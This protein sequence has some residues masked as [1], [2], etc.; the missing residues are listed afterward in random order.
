VVLIDA[1]EPISE[2]DQRVL[3]MVVDAGRA[4]VIALNKWDL[5]DDDRRHYLARELERDLRRIPWA[6]RV[7][8]SAKTG[9][10]VD[11]LAPALHTALASWEQRV[12]TGPLNQWLTAVVNATPHPVRSGRSPK[13]LFATQ[14][15]TRPPRFVLFTSGPLDASYVRFIERRLREEYGFAGSPVVVSVRSRQRK[16]ARRRSA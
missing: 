10:A 1:S 9:R 5:V 7:N 8:V 3:S 6:L 13:V 4:M 11:K 15:G 12:P 14:A 16:S 2:Q